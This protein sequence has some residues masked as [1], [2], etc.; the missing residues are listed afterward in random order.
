[1]EAGGRSGPYLECP[2][3][4]TYTGLKKSSANIRSRCCRE[5]AG[6]PT[7]PIIGKGS[8]RYEQ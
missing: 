3:A 1:M 7:P 8:Y 5:A 2:I 6:Q 4:V